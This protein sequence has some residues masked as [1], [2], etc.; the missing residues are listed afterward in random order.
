[1]AGGEA[2]FGKVRFAIVEECVVE[3]AARWDTDWAFALRDCFQCDIDDFAIDV[4]FT[5]EQARV[6]L[7]RI[8][9]NVTRGKKR[10]GDQCSFGRRDRSIEC[11]R[12][13]RRDFRHACGSTERCFGSATMSPA[14]PP[15]TA[16][17]G[18]Q[19]RPRAT[20]VGKQPDV[21]S[22]LRGFGSAVFSTRCRCRRSMPMKLF[23]LPQWRSARRE[24]SQ[25]RSAN[26][27][28]RT[29]RAKRKISRHNEA[30][31]CGRLQ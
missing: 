6:H 21:F 28:E 10:Q 8:V 13:G 3:W 22:D 31:K 14:V 23:A 12:S 29:C 30:C 19:Y 24:D 20:C 7:I 27:P 2:S 9:T 18:T 15:T 25:R 17:V 1:M 16:S 5:R 11:R 4:R 26:S